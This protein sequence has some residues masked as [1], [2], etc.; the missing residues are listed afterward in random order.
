MNKLPI[1]LI[2][3][4]SNEL[5]C[6]DCYRKFCR[7]LN[8]NMNDKKLD[9]LIFKTTCKECRIKKNQECDLFW[10]YELQHIHKKQRKNIKPKFIN[11]NK[12]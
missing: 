1:E 4:I 10:E 3:M 11:F 7:S 2:Y 12:I 9:L 8:L 6:Y 5:N